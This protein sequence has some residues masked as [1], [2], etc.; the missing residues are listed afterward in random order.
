MNLRGQINNG[1]FDINLYNFEK[2]RQAIESKADPDQ[3]KIKINF[4]NSF[5][6]NNTHEK[7]D[8]IIEDNNKR[9]TE[10]IEHLLGKEMQKVEDVVNLINRVEA[11]NL[12]NK[13]IINESEMTINLNNESN[14]TK[15][16]SEMIMIEDIS[17]INKTNKND[18]TMKCEFDT[19]NIEEVI[20]E[21]IEEVSV[22]T[23]DKFLED[24]QIPNKIEKEYVHSILRNQMKNIVTSI[25]ERKK[26]QESIKSE[27]KKNIL[28]NLQNTNTIL[29]DQMI[30]DILIKKIN[31]Q[32]SKEIQPPKPEVI[33]FGK[34]KVN[35]VNELRKP[36][37]NEIDYGDFINED[38]RL[39][40]ENNEALDENEVT[41]INQT[42]NEEE[43]EAKND[44]TNTCMDNT[45][46]DKTRLIESKQL[47]DM[48]EFIK[49]NTK[50][51]ILVDPEEELQY[52]EI[53]Q[54]K[55]NNNYKQKRFTIGNDDE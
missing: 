3:K 53:Q 47:F 24:T 2:K 29:D 46:N 22:D 34:V 14:T 5:V 38:V 20:E 39:N 1:N 15:N 17:C 43:T 12:S 8:K 48:N 4:K 35:E 33:T 16:E 30:K 25:K 40:N 52:A 54:I 19:E 55:S 50:D 49:E 10:K 23:Y 37:S 41:Q 32:S 42:V 44:C 11:T 45:C 21:D 6:N 18:D 51:E 7:Y 9:N 36:S 28:L 27:K 26:G 31:L 13:K